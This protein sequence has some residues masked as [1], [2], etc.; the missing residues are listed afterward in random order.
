MKNK[1]AQ[2]LHQQFQATLKYYPAIELLPDI[3][4]QVKLFIIDMI[5]N[6]TESD[7]LMP[8]TIN[9]A[10]ETISLLQISLIST[11]PADIYVR[12][13]VD[14]ASILKA[15]IKKIQQ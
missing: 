8:S 5:E 13:N 14:T 6:M 2:V 15:A 11:V 9:M 10:K 4:H 7:L 3:H 12:N 1:L